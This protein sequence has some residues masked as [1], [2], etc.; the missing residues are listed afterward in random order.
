[1]ATDKTWLERCMETGNIPDYYA[2]LAKLTY[3]IPR[4]G[5][6]REITIGL[7]SVPVKI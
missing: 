2:K 3:V 4:R 1:M 5:G 6:K 7:K